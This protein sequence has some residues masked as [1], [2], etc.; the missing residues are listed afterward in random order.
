MAL[1]DSLLHNLEQNRFRGKKETIQKTNIWYK[2][3]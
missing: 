2:N 1:L 3:K